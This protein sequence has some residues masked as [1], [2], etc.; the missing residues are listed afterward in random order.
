M[1]IKE[2]GLT[3]KSAQ[4]RRENMAGP[5]RKGF[6]AFREMAKGK[7]GKGEGK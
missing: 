3:G 4:F 2:K 7:D 5:G 1:K 6:N